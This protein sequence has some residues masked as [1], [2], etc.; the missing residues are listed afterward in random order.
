MAQTSG[1]FEAE[2]DA[3]LFNEE[4]QSYGDWDRKYLAEQFARYFSKF[5]STGVMND[6][7]NQLKVSAGSGMN[8]VV[9]PGF[10]FINGFWYYNTEQLVLAVP[11]NE[12]PSTRYDSV[13]L[14][15][16]ASDRAIECIYVADDITNIRNDLYYDLQLAQVSIAASASVVTDANITD[17][18]SNETLCGLINLVKAEDIGDL[19]ALTTSNK[20]TIV[21]AINSLVTVIGSLGS[22]NTEVKTSVVA[23]INYIVSIIGNLDDLNTLQKNTLVNAINTIKWAGVQAKPFDILDGS[24]IT[25]KTIDGKAALVAQH[26]ADDIVIPYQQFVFTNLQ[27][28]INNAA[29]TEDSLADVFF[30]SNSIDYAS[31]AKISVETYNGYLVLTAINA[32][33]GN[34]Y[35][36]IRV[37]VV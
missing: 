5:V 20:N 26:A 12:T 33:T 31:K 29:I 11:L 7:E 34:I 2:W 8:V 16:N 36:T 13:R 4:T 18:R 27:C 37:R 30:A 19:D 22:L 10:A 21:G 35:G 23:A 14:R 1:F 9:S 28:Q 32:P 24:T 15:W 17:V 25:T 3:E 6:V